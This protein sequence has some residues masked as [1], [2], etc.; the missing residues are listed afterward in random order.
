MSHTAYS[1]EGLDAMEQQL[2][3]MI[4]QEFP[5]E[6]KQKVIEIAYELQGRVKQRTPYRTGL[7]QDRWEVGRLEKR[8]NEY[9]IEVYNNVEYAEAVEYGH[10]T[11]GSNGF[12]PG[13]HMMEISMA[14]IS[15][16]LP[17]YLQEWLNDFLETHDL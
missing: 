4:E 3:Q 8:G 16:R 6:F 5:D 11:R 7:L 13:K 15:E 10:R 14:E 2:V 1:F 9:Y 17:A 12:V